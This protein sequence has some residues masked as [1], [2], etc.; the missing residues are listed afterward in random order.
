MNQ[1]ESDLTHYCS[2][3]LLSTFFMREK[4]VFFHEVHYNGGG[5]YLREYTTKTVLLFILIQFN[6]N[7]ITVSRLLAVA[8]FMCFV[9]ILYPISFLQLFP[10]HLFSPSMPHFPLYLD[11]PCFFCPLYITL[12][13]A[14]RATHLSSF[15][16]QWVDM[17]SV[18]T[19]ICADNTSVMEDA[20]A[21][22]A[23]LW[24]FTTSEPISQSE[25]CSHTDVIWHPI[26]SRGQTS[27]ITM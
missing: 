10:L 2:L 18:T 3:I 1:N 24:L 26:F 19:Q 7:R 4:N 27:W 25:G 15:L 21:Q 5:I 22:S 23:S 13:V 17:G 16:L 6:Y 9:F 12:T 14:E 11:S 8:S 20:A